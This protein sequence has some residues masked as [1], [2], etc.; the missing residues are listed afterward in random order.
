MSAKELGSLYGNKLL[1]FKME[2]LLLIE[3]IDFFHDHIINILTLIIKV[4][5]ES[6]FGDNFKNLEFDAYIIITNEL[7]DKRFRVLE[8]DNHTII[9][10]SFT[11]SEY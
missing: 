11:N 2:F 6:D 3:A 8:V 10:Y 7:E 9:P 5:G 4:V 1:V